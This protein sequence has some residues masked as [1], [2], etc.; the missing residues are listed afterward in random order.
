MTENEISWDY[1]AEYTYH[2]PKQIF[3]THSEIIEFFN[4]IHHLYYGNPD[5]YIKAMAN[6]LKIN[7]P[8]NKD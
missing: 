3:T 4:G 2:L 1:S 6:S 8:V 7:I 5:A